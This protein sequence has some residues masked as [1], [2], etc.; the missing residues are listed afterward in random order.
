[1]PPVR[2]VVQRVRRAEVRVGD[3]VVGSI[4][5]GLCVLLGVT[6]VDADADAVRLCRKIVSLRIF[7]DAAGHMNRSVT[8]VAGAMRAF[9]ASEKGGSL[10]SVLCHMARNVTTSLQLPGGSASACRRVFFVR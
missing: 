5:Q 2:A 1:M 6:D 7:D 8:D 10:S 4:A 3:A 9:D